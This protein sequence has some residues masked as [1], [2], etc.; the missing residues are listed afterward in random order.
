MPKMKTHRGAAKR[1]KK[2]G[3][4]KIKR[5]KA[6]AGHLLSSKSPKRKRNLRKGGLVSPEETKRISKLIPY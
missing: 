3:S 4:G 5:A 1:F 2:T 6:Y